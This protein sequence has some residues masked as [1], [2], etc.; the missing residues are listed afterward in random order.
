MTLSLCEVFRVVRDWKK[1]HYLGFDLWPADDLEKKRKH[2]KFCFDTGYLT[3]LTDS[4]DRLEGFLVFYRAPH[5]DGLDMNH[6]EPRGRYVVCEALWIKPDIRGTGA[7]KRLIQKAV[8]ENR[9]KLQGA[10]TL[11]FHDEK[12]NFEEMFFDFEK[13]SRKYAA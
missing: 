5:F 1:Q 10:K 3:L 6:A 7:L 2:L 4:K 12:H 13:F 9:E 8:W 11:V